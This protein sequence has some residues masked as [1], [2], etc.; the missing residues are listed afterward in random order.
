M[1]L[2]SV[3]RLITAFLLFLVSVSAQNLN[4][5][6]DRHKA[7]FEMVKNDIK[8]NYY[9]QDLRG[10]DIE[11]KYKTS[12]ER[13]E[14]ANSISQMSAIIAQFLLDFDDSHLFFLPPGKVNKT[15][16]GFDMRMIGDKCFVNQIDEKSD[17]AKKG[18]QVGDEI[19]ALEGYAPTRNTLWKM[20][21]FFY[22]LNPRSTLRLVV[23]KPSR[24]EITY[25]VEAKIT[26]GKQITDLTGGDV[27]KVI[28]E[29]EDSERKATKQYFY[30]KTE[31]L[32]IWKMRGFS[33]EPSK[34][35]DIMN[36]AKKSSALILDL[37]GNGGG[38]VD[39]LLRLLG[40][41]FPE[42]IKVGDE[43]KRKETK[44]ILVKSRGKDS[45]TGKL[46]VLTDSSSASASEVFS[47]VIQSEKR[48]LIIGDQTA[49]AVMES[50]YFGHQVGLDVV[51][52]FGASVTIADLI[53]KDGKSLEKIGVTPDE[54][55]L[56][57]QSDLANQRDPVL[58][59][60]AEVLGFKITP[61]E[62]GKIFPIEYDK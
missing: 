53:M 10:I 17:A 34:V 42:N 39:M 22:R 6:R 28:R 58:S 11:A 7:M 4:F 30:D 27:Y 24:K 1:N 9:D 2:N 8:K 25:E 3:I 50:R 29:S 19:E 33:L 31:G 55:R 21:Y 38:R 12:V 62:A 47:K 18:L 35:D 37:R 23:I 45:F 26:S 52:F 5:E 20:N 49:G 16:Y 43:K 14:K 61:E 13:L 46:V 59:R 56:P 60:A 15:D 57:T 36:K 44:E 41:F 51:V 32:L 54:K 48:G 40:N